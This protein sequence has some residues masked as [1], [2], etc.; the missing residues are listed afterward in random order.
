[1]C[2]HVKSFVSRLSILIFIFISEVNE[3]SNVQ[4][5]SMQNFHKIFGVFSQSVRS[6][7]SRATQYPTANKLKEYNRTSLFGNAR[8]GRD[9][10][11]DNWALVFALLLILV[12]THDAA[13]DARL[14]VA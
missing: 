4:N 13:A 7:H 14:I 3:Q 9:M 2:V 12:S 6:K 1:M 8:Q 11:L 10:L 5:L